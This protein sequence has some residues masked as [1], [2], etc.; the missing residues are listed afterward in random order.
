MFILFSAFAMGIFAAII[1]GPLILSGVAS[2][3]GNDKKG[4][5]QAIR[6]VLVSAVAEFFIASGIVF[7]GK[8][9][10]M[11]PW[12]FIILG[13]IGSALL[14]WLSYQLWNAQSAEVQVQKIQFSAW[15]MVGITIFNPMLWSLWITVSMPLAVQVGTTLWLGEIWYVVCFLLGLIIGHS[16]IFILVEIIKERFLNPAYTSKIFQLVSLGFIAFALLVLWNTFS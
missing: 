10:S 1:P 15:Q 3:L 16:L 9:I 8:Q 5:I 6:L 4:L 13:I 14:F 7:F 11:F 2:I 12:I